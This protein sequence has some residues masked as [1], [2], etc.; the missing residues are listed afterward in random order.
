MIIARRESAVAH[1]PVIFWFNTDLISLEIRRNVLWVHHFFFSVDRNKGEWSTYHFHQM[2][3]KSRQILLPNGQWFISWTPSSACSCQHWLSNIVINV[4]INI[5]SVFVHTW[6][7]VARS[8]SRCKRHRLSR[9][10]YI[11]LNATNVKKLLNHDPS[12]TAN[13]SE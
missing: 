2:P 10:V 8:D 4:M 7:F 13:L 3:G 6:F 1:L 5:C 11:V 9:V 12:T